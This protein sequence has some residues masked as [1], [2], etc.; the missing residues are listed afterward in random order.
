[1]D[2]NKPLID[3]LRQGIVEVDFNSK[4]AIDEDMR[5]A[6]DELDRLWELAYSPHGSW[7]LDSPE[8]TYSTYK[9][10]VEAFRRLAGEWRDETV[11]LEK[12]LARLAERYYELEQAY[13]TMNNATQ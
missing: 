13:F 10:G 9:N 8:P 2:M 12:E 11:R 1:M 3:R 4:F 7:N 5:E 6:A